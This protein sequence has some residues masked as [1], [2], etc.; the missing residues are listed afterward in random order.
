MKEEILE[1]FRKIE[2]T[3]KQT[4]FTGRLELHYDGIDAYE[5][6]K[7][8]ESITEYPRIDHLFT[9]SEEVTVYLLH[10]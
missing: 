8:I 1:K 6:D 2:Q 5:W 9:V 7:I 10:N 4:G 3:A